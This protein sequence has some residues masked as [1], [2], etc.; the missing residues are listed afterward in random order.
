MRTYIASADA[1][2]P[3]F[4]KLY[5]GQITGPIFSHDTV[6]SELYVNQNIKQSLIH[7]P[8]NKTATS[9]ANNG[10]ALTTAHSM[11]TF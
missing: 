5:I 11:W 8:Q 2:S 10:L 1:E 9:V 4:S 3:T 7:Q 6:H